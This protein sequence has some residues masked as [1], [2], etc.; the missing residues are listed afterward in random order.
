MKKLKPIHLRK[1]SE[2]VSYEQMMKDL[3]DETGFTRVDVDYVVT[4]Y[5]KMVRKELLERKLV[6]LRGLG[7]LFPMVRAPRF[8]TDLRT[9]VN[10]VYEKLHTPAVWRVKFQV[11][12]KLRED[13]ADIMVT[14]RDLEKMYY[15]EE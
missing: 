11:E 12:Q 3:A 15:K 4:T 10:G 14:K 13:A 2:S 6:K 1:P 9:F 7:S 8:V 5:L